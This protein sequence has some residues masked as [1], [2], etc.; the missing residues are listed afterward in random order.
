MRPSALSSFSNSS[1]RSISDIGPF[2]S[3]KNTPI[4][5]TIERFSFEC[6]KTKTKVI[7]LTNHNSCKQSNEPIRA[8]SKYM[9]PAPNSGKTRAGKSRLVLVLLL[10]GRESGAGFFSQSQTVAMQ[11]QSNCVITFDTQLKSTI[12]ER[13]SIDFFSI[14]SNSISIFF[15]IFSF[16]FKIMS[17]FSWKT[18]QN[19][20][21]LSKIMLENG[22]DNAAVQRFQTR[23]TFLV[24]FQ[25]LW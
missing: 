6:R 9:K 20:L 2:C 24:N 12:L 13:F 14:F 18:D 21:G 25:N 11:N 4:A 10:I 16:V 15:S 1:R 23:R 3:T 22:A 5:H 17:F 8:R 7:T 19:C